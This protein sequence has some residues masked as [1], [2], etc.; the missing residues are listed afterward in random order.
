M[1]THPIF[2]SDFDCLTEF[3]MSENEVVSAP[4]E[5][6]EMEVF[7]DSITM[8]G[9]TRTETEERNVNDSS[10]ERDSDSDDGICVTADPITGPTSIN[11]TNKLTAAPEKKSRL[12]SESS[13]KQPT[14]KSEKPLIPNPEIDA[15][16]DK[17]WQKPGAD[18]SDYFNYGFSESTWRLYSEHQRTLRERAKAILIARGGF[19]PPVKTEFNGP[20]PVFDSKDRK[21]VKMSGMP[22]GFPP[23]MMPPGFPPG[24]PPGMPP[25]VM[26]PMPGMPPG[27][28][29][30][31][32]M[33]PGF[34]PGMP[35][36]GFP[37]MPP[38]IKHERDIKTER[39]EGRRNFESNRYSRNDSRSDHR[40][41]TRDN[42]DRDRD[43]DRG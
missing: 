30:P 21:P 13:D 26:P 17:P 41:R 20:P 1:G 32:M 10:S 36:P 42:R 33:P 23:G 4:H 18:L 2:E 11:L 27:M 8:N 24:M 14:S 29:P 22:P 5:K 39:G 9:V 6:I 25:G 16:D 37:G 3:K 43:R 34:P 12:T 35:P 38:D 7:S 40:D 15:L 31:G 28:P 19:V